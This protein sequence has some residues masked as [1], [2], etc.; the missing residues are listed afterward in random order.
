MD[1][2]VIWAGTWNSV[3]IPGV[4]AFVLAVVGYIVAWIAELITRRL[5]KDLYYEEWFEA[6]GV[7]RAFLGITITDLVATI[8]KW[9]VFLGFF[10]QA[11]ALFNLDFLMGMATTLYNIYISIALGIIYLA[12]WAII[13]QYVGV[14]MRESAYYGGEIAVKAV[15]AV[16]MYFAVITALPYFGIRDTYIITRALEIALWAAGAGFALGIGL[17]FGLGAQ[18]TVKDILK[19]KKERI[20]EIFFGKKA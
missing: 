19:K 7:N 20:E 11:V 8:V 14:K 13:A 2:S 9:W 16:I 5:F 4:S 1:W 6:H 18:D 15:Q 10:S 3:I 17:A 12:I